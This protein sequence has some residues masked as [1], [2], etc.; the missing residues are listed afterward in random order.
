MGFAT[1]DAKAQAKKKNLKIHKKEL[2]NKIYWD[3]LINSQF[4]QE[5]KEHRTVS[6]IEM[7]S[8]T[9]E[10]KEAKQTKMSAIIN[11]AENQNTI[12][13]HDYDC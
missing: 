2:L 10:N 3:Q 8:M 12:N 7:Q 9:S 1:R 5:E 4:K 6:H 11:D 13:K